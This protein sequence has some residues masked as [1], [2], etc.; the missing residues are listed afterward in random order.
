MNIG[1][2]NPLSSMPHSAC[3]NLFQGL[4]HCWKHFLNSVMGLCKSCCITLI[5]H[6]SSA[7]SLMIS[8]W[9]ALTKSCTSALT[10]S[11]LLHERRPD[12]RSLS[13]QIKGYAPI[14]RWRNHSKTYVRLTAFSQK[15]VLTIH[16]IQVLFSLMLM[17]NEETVCETSANLNKWLWLS[18]Q[19]DFIDYSFQNWIS[20]DFVPLDVY[21]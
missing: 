21:V 7:T 15:A 13:A 18:T 2:T 19:D 4:F 6:C 12:P 5:V 3:V 9:S 8:I 11:F 1:Q 10:I 16:K 17:I 20:G 14:V